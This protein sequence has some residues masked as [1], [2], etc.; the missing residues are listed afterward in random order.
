MSAAW[1]LGRRRSWDIAR[2]RE[3]VDNAGMDVHLQLER[4]LHRRVPPS[5]V[6]KGGAFDFFRWFRSNHSHI[7]AASRFR[8]L[9]P[10]AR[11]LFVQL[12]PFNAFPLIASLR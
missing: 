3:F 12:P 6:S 5:S 7:N 2:A 1:A 10:G 4:V 11:S 8:F 9:I